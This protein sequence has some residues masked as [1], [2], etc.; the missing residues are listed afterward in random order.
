MR[1]PSPLDCPVDPDPIHEHGLGK[2]GACVRCADET[3]SCG[4]IEQNEGRVVE[5]PV[6]T[7]REVSR[8]H[9]EIG[10][11]VDQPGDGALIPFHGEN[12]ES[13]VETPQCQDMSPREGR[14]AGI[15]RAAMARLPAPS[16]L[17]LTGRSVSFS[18]WALPPVGADV[19]PPP[20]GMGKLAGR[21]VEFVLPGEPVFEGRAFL[22]A[23]CHGSQNHERPKID[24]SSAHVAGPL[25]GSS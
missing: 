11:A 5:F 25:G 20:P 12:V 2:Y 1:W 22:T 16:R 7:G 10:V 23:T 14:V 15:P 21:A 4:H 17:T 9:G 24:R 8:S 19:E 3:P 18:S 6:C 13:Q